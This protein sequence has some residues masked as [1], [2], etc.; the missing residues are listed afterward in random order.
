VYLN[1]ERVTGHLGCTRAR[2]VPN[3]FQVP[4]QLMIRKSAAGVAQIGQKLKSG[5]PSNV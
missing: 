4:N 2:L 3:E 5:F 1:L